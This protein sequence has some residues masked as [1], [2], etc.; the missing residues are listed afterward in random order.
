M[1]AG[2]PLVLSGSEFRDLAGWRCD[3]DSLL[4]LRDRFRRISSDLTA[5]S[6][7][8]ARCA[9]VIQEEAA[10][11]QKLELVGILKERRK[12]LENPVGYDI[13]Q[14]IRRPKQQ[15][16][17][18]SPDNDSRADKIGAFSKPYLFLSG[19]D[20]DMDNEVVKPFFLYQDH[21]ETNDSKRKAKRRGYKPLLQRSRGY[22]LEKRVQHRKE[23]D[24]LMEEDG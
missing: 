6:T 9:N 15:Q 14:T 18:P 24:N 21:G 1:A 23:F 2:F 4:Q 11:A 22:S 12:Q 10:H 17:P 20:D 7:L 3:R 19:D 5:K 8:A 13:L 16:Q